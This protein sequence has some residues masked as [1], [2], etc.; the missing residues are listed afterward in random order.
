MRQPTMQEFKCREHRSANDNWAGAR[1]GPAARTSQSRRSQGAGLGILVSG[2]IGLA[3]FSC[4]LGI[5]TVELL[6]R[7]V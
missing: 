6:L 2:L 5:V 7:L 1:A 4:T 3:V